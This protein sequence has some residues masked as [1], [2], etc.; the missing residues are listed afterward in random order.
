MKLHQLNLGLDARQDRLL[1]RV[2]TTAGKEFRF[3]LTRRLV[4]RCWPAWV[5]VMQ[6]AE[7]FAAAIVP[8]E[9]RHAAAV[10]QADFATPYAATDPTQAPAAAP[11]LL[12]QFALCAAAPD[13][14]EM[15][16][17]TGNGSTLNLKLAAAHLHGFVQL[18]QVAVRDADWGLTLALPGAA[19][20]SRA[21][22]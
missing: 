14:Y 11:L 21:I 13:H 7:G 19:M 10:Q 15:K 9:F 16:L 8:L 20:A 2:S 17:T 6:Q 22:N 18:L 12:L 3:W 4:Q 5:S 1:L